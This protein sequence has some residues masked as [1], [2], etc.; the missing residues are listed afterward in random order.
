V[1]IGFDINIKQMSATRQSP[2]EE[3]STVNLPLFLITLPRTSKT[4]EIFKLT[5]ICHIAVRAEVCKAHTGLMQCYT[6]QKF[7]HVW[8]N[9]KQ[10]PHFMWCGGGHLHKEW[11]EKGNAASLSTCCNWKLVDKDD[12]HPLTI[13]AAAMPRMR[14]EKEYIRKGVF[15]QPHH[16]WTVLSNS[17]SS[18][19]FPLLHRPALP[20]WE[21]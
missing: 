14:Y 12:S 13:E 2:A 10:P 9:C 1:D 8:A 11:L 15:F 20:K 7:S 6:C 5:S 18:F 4:Q 3:T 19:I 17:S 16:P 21:K